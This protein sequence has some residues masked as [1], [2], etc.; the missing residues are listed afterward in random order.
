MTPKTR[1]MNVRTISIPPRSKYPWQTINVEESFFVPAH[2]PKTVEKFIKQ[3][4]I[5]ATRAGKKYHRR[6]ATRMV[7]ERGE[8]GIRIWRTA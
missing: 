7:H 8:D 6:F 5:Q 4:R 3:M 2:D 1:T